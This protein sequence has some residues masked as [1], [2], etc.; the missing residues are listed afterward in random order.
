M[1]NKA[2]SPKREYQT[3]DETA[4]IETIDR[5]KAR[6]AERFPARGLT[7]TAGFLADLTRSISPI[8]SSF[9]PST[10]SKL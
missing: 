3:L 10:M 2:P 9:P 1:A 6:V 5:L 7:Q 4:I 8:L